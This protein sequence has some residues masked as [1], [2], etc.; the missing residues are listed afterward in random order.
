MTA[1]NFVVLSNPVAGKDAEYNDWYTN[2]HLGDVLR[3]KGFTGARRYKL[4]ETAEGTHAYMALY[5]ME[6]DDP[7]KVI[8]DMMAKAGTPELMISPAIDIEGVTTVLYKAIT[9]HV[10]APR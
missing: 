8:A 9:P 6:T 2:T 1:Y 4:D 5:E 3:V 10:P 7:Q